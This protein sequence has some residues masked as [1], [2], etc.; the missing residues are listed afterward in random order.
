[1]SSFYVPMMPRLEGDKPTPFKT[2]FEDTN[3]LLMFSAK[4]KCDD[5]AKT[6]PGVTCHELDDKALES[7]LDKSLRDGF[8]HVL[9]DHITHRPISEFRTAP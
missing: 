8:T 2:R 6:R 9:I 5:Y 3:S 1:M 7:Q 4:Q